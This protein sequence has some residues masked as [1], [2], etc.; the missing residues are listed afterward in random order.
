MFRSREKKSMRRK[1]REG[2]N[3]DERGE[4]KINEKTERERNV[5]LDKYAKKMQRGNVRGEKK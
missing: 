4:K 5:C 1:E 3:D 2:R